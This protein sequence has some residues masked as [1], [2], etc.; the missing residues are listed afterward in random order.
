MSGELAKI[1]ELLDYLTDDERTEIDALLSANAPV[2]VPLPGPQTE[3]LESEADILFYGGA[4]GGGK[5]DLLIGASLTQHVKSLILRRESTQLQGILDRITEILGG[6]DGY[7]GQEKV[8]RMPDRQMEFGSVKDSGDEIKYQGRPHDLLGF[9]EIC[10]FLESQFRFLLGW[11]RTTKKGQRCRV[12]CTGNPPTDSD[13]QWVKQFWGPWLDKKHPN[14][15]KPGELRWYAMIDGKEVEC[16]DGSRFIHAGK[17]IKPKSRTFIP[18]RIQDNAYL[19]ATDY[20]STLQALPEPLRSQMLNGD[21]TAGTDDDPFQTIPTA[22][23][24]AAMERWTPEGKRRNTMDSV[25]ADIARGGRDETIITPRHA[26]WFAEQTCYPGAQTPDGSTSASLILAN[27][28]DA[29]PIHVDVI[30]VGSS[31]YDHLN[32]NNIHVIAVNWAEKATRT[33][34]TGKLKFVNLRA[35]HWWSMREAL[36]PKTGDDLALPPCPKLLADLTA[37]RWKLTPRGIQIES[38]DDL[39]KRIGRSP[40]RGDS[41]VLALICTEKRDSEDDYCNDGGDESR[42]RV[43]GY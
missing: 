8:W 18:S 21:F 19:M 25:G 15:A 35:Q 1:S 10:H 24:E 12:I 5:S 16:A 39:V 22:W 36:D 31:V 41:A 3:A 13:G 43:G 14:P 11:L 38:K 4:A 29:A 20:E 30:G 34:K 33:D 9:D 32:D 28:R 42:S 23:I 7:N 26:W 6:R 2:W 37:P 17:S 27:T 40:D